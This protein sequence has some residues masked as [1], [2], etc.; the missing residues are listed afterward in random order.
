MVQISIQKEKP[1]LKLKVSAN[2]SLMNYIDTL[3]N[4]Q[5]FQPAILELV[6]EKLDSCGVNIKKSQINSLV[7]SLGKELNGVVHSLDQKL[8]DMVLY[9]LPIIC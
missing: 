5:M 8:Q 4:S 6:P 1:M 3:D 9:I 2:P 7:C